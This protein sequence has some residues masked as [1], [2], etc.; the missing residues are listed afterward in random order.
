M[1]EGARIEARVRRWAERLVR[2]AQPKVAARA[3]AVRASAFV[4]GTPRKSASFVLDLGRELF[5]TVHDL[6]RGLLQHVHELPDRFGE[7]ML[8]L[9]S[10][11]GRF[12]LAFAY[13]FRDGSLR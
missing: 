1:R 13:G 11:L 2:A 12:I 6:F 4:L 10:L 5:G 9:F 3:S 8:S 7:A